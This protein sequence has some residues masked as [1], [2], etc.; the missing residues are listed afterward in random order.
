MYEFLVQGHLDAS[1]PSA[2]YHNVTRADGPGGK[3]EQPWR[4]GHCGAGTS[5]L[6]R[7]PL[8]GGVRKREKQAER[9]ALKAS[10]PVLEESPECRAMK[11]AGQSEA[12]ALEP[13]EGCL[14]GSQIMMLVDTAGM[15]AGTVATMTD[16][17]RTQWLL[18]N[19]RKVQKDDEGTY[20]AEVGSVTDFDEAIAANSNAG[21]SPPPLGQLGAAGVLSH[22][23]RLRSAYAEPVPDLPLCPGEPA[24]TSYL[25][26]GTKGCVDYCFYDDESLE[27][28]GRLEMLPPN[29]LRRH[30][31]GLPT[32]AW[33]SDHM[34][35]VME[36]GVK[37]P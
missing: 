24:F 27:L 4:E 20:W 23:L 36:F 3:A 17:N 34:A 12:E 28:L 35:L 11:A 13:K 37:P 1:D 10:G 30:G 9:E 29:V 19:H 32:K 31:A 26:E 8:A 21:A 16:Q 2:V 7:R 5:L 15:D 14:V 18:H 6:E 33:S 25:G 22:R